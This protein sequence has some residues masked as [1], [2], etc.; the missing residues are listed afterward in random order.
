MIATAYAIALSC[1]S[2]NVYHEARNQSLLGQEAVALVTMNRA[3]WNNT[4]I[5]PEVVKHKQFSWTNDKV[6]LVKNHYRL[7]N[8]GFPKEEI[9]WEKSVAIAKKVMKHKVVP[10]EIHEWDYDSRTK[11]MQESV[12]CVPN[13]FGLTR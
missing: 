6:Y 4:N 2:L 5:C 11:N 3:G 1:L 7:K 12:V 13:R 9:A 8:S 10:K